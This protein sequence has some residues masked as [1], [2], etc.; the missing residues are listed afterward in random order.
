MRSSL[1]HKFELWEGIAR[2]MGFTKLKTS[3]SITLQLQ[4]IILVTLQLGHNHYILFII[5]NTQ[6]QAFISYE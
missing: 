1:R 3:V 2:L 4:S 6:T 5:Y